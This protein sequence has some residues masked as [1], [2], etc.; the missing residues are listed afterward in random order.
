M[1]KIY[2]L[3]DLH[4]GARTLKNPLENERRVVR[5]FDSVKEDAS[6]IYL[7]GDILDYWY[8]YKTVVP[9]GFTRFFGKVAELTDKGI[10]VHWFIGNHDIWIFDYLPGELGVKVH[11]A[12]EI[13]DLNGKTF[14]LAHGD[15]LGDTPL[16][17]RF[18]RSVFHNRLCQMLYSAI[19]PRWTVAFAHKWS[20]HSRQNG[21]CKDYCGEDNEYLVRYAKEYLEKSSVHI[22]FFVFGHRH[23]MLDLMIRRD[24][25]VIIL[26]DWINYFSYAVLEGDQ[27]RLEQFEG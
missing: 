21:N 15:G 19:H 4:L 6:A 22:D 26:G 27:M 23:I 2:F 3:S 17:F 16:T 10:D 25:R 20:S 11:Y 7:M 24:S 9:R 13:V 8:E 18:I 12:P 1:K 14:Y 5:W